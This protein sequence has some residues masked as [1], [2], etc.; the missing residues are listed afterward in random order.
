MKGYVITL[1]MVFSIFLFMG[2]LYYLST[3]WNSRVQQLGAQ[4]DSLLRLRAE[5]ALTDLSE[6]MGGHRISQSSAQSVMNQFASNYTQMKN[7]LGMED[8][9]V[10]LLMT[11]F[12]GIVLYQTNTTPTG[13][14]VVTA[15]RYAYMNQPVRLDLWVWQ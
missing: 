8:S 14:L 15:T 6:R 4:E 9:D 5:Q 10:K 1:D 11:D 7:S 13:S 12:N 3:A 2:L